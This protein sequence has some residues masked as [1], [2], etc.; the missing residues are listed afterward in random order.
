MAAILTQQQKYEE[1]R[2]LYQKL[3]ESPPPNADSRGS[4]RLQFEVARLSF[5]L[6]DFKASAESFDT[7]RKALE[8][9]GGRRAAR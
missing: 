5:L 2:N 1:A 3:L 8:Q 4:N 7:V 9:D 6:G